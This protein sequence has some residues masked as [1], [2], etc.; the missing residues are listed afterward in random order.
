VRWCWDVF[1]VPAFDNNRGWAYTVD[2]DTA[3][4]FTAWWSTDR[5]GND[6][7]LLYRGIISTMGSPPSGWLQ[8]DQANDHA[9]DD[10]A[11]LSVSD[12]V[13]PGAYTVYFFNR[14]G[15]EP[16]SAGGV[17]FFSQACP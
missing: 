4:W 1:G 12:Y 9:D 3:S 2:V 5:N 8:R 13:S 7:I 17:S 14:G 15:F 16:A 10:R 11:T 6:E